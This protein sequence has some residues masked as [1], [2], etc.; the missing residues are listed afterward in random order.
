VGDWKLEDYVETIK[1]SAAFT[2]RYYLSIFLA[3]L[4]VSV[5]TVFLFLVILFVGSIPLSVAYGPFDE[6]FDVFDSIGLVLDRATDVEAVGIV[7]FVGSAMLA[8][9]L[10]ALG[11]L[12]GM[13]QEVM[14]SGSVSAEETLLWY[15]QKF[16]RLAAGGIAQFLF[17]I[18]PIGLEYILAA[19]YY[20]NQMPD[21]TAFSILVAIA[22]FWFLFSSGSLSMVFPSIVDGMTLSSS[23]RHAIGLTRSDFKAVFSIWITF[24]SLGLLLLAPVI[25][26]EF[27]D[28]VILTGVWY[29]FYLLLSA[30]TLT[31]VLLPLYVLSATRTYLII[32]GPNTGNTQ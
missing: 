16:T 10:I 25:F 32:S 11:A 5:I 7:L 8:P 28:F 14:E 2:R 30:V 4:G 18:G 6:V 15:R 9:F 24:S 21:G 3:I 12:F 27:A 23:I 20:T 22:V 1:L 17:I 13:G 29:D 26:Q 31:M 19:S